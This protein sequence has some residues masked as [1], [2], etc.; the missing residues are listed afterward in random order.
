MVS[1]L[2][3]TGRVRLNAGYCPEAFSKIGDKQTL[4]TSNLKEDPKARKVSLVLQK[5][6]GWASQNRLNY[7]SFY[8]EKQH[9]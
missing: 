3:I 8:E 1:V 5:I 6:P 7:S 4:K 9:Q 2:V